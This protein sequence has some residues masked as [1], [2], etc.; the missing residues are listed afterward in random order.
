MKKFFITGTDT[1]VGKTITSA[2]L[3]YALKSIY[4]KP[5]QSGLCESLSD[6]DIV[7]QLNG[8][9]DCHFYPTNYALQA[10]LSPNQAAE[11]EKISIHLDECILPNTSK[12]ILVEGAGGLYV[13]LNEEAYMLD[14]IKKLN[15]PVIIV[16][17]GTLGTIN[18]TLLTINALR[19]Q[20]LT[21]HGVIF[22]GHLHVENRNDIERL[23]NV[24]TL[25]H[26]PHFEELNSSTLQNWVGENELKIKEVFL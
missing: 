21:P 7:Q 20:G 10:S 9:A 5:I 3:S 15:L 22:C 12:H 2:V 11:L 17:R 1:N 25:L 8:L 23:G 18:H 16:A 26:I 4:W 24:P 19:Q 6:R 14:L 13:P